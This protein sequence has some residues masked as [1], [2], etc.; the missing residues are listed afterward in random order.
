MDMS[1]EFVGFDGRFDGRCPPV[2][3]HSELE[4]HHFYKKQLIHKWKIFHS[5]VRFPEGNGIM[6]YC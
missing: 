1:W 3:S 5:Y 2:I 4:N 6:G